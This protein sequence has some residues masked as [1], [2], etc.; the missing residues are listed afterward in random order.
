[1][2]SPRQQIVEAFAQQA[3]HSGRGVFA[4]NPDDF[5]AQQQ[6][7]FADQMA[8]FPDEAGLEDLAR[9]LRRFT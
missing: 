8:A 9:A 1:M 5:I 3:H 6:R 4:R 7:E 2:V